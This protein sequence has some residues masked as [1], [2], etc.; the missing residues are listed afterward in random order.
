MR[1][2]KDSAQASTKRTKQSWS[3]SHVREI[4]HAAT[5][6]SRCRWLPSIGI[7]AI[8]R[9]GCVEEDQTWVPLKTWVLLREGRKML[10][11]CYCHLVYHPTGRSELI[12]ELIHFWVFVPV[13]STILGVWG[14]D[15]VI[16]RGGM[17]RHFKALRD[18]R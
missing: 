1:G 4:V 13:I 6:D 10:S 15:I 12:L 2:S 8:P 14:I 18:L 5:L 7:G 9:R 3:L 16:T 17:E 11:C